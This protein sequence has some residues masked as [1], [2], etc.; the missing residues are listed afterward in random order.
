MEFY[1]VC[2][3]PHLLAISLSS[4]FS[5]SWRRLTQRECGVKT[6]ELCVQLKRL[7][8]SL[9]FIEK[10]YFAVVRFSNPIHKLKPISAAHKNK[11]NTIQLKCIENEFHRNR[12]FDEKEFMCAQS[13]QLKMMIRQKL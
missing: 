10:R 2:C 8:V 6:C 4:P 12:M 13:F 3:W 5:L 11:C 1:L 7:L 9:K